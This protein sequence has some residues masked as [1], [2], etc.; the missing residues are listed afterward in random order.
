MHCES[1][2]ASSSRT[3]RR[4][5]KFHGYTKR[6]VKKTLTI[7]T[8]NRKRRISWCRQKLHWTLNNHWKSVIF[9]DETQVKTNSQSRVSVWR[10]P[11][12]VWRPECLGQ[13]GGRCLSVMFWGCVTYH[14]V[15]TLEPVL[16]NIDSEKYILVECL[17]QN[18][19][20]VIAKNF[21]D[22]GYIFLEDN[23]PVHT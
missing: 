17:D 4:R 13:R 19:W 3:V 10:K 11:D 8:T 23:A 22:G 14:G 16:G 7:N 5:L 18:V 21:P 20:P 6:K 2:I 9:S 12:E 15:G 1:N